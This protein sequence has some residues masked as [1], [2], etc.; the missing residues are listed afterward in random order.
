M[1]INIR[2]KHLFAIFTISILTYAIYLLYKVFIS[3]TNKSLCLLNSP[4]F[5]KQYKS[6]DSQ[7]IQ[8]S[9]HNYSFMFWINIDNWEYK[10]HEKKHIFSKGDNIYKYELVK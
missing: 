1:K 4:H 2:F 8:I 9:G 3:V 7:V 5:G 6:A 10:L